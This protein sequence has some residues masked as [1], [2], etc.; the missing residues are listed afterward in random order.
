M[1]WFVPAK[2]TSMARLSLVP[3]ASRVQVTSIP[4]SSA[5]GSAQVQ[6]AHGA[7]AWA[8][9][10]SRLSKRSS[11]V[12]SALA[13]A[14]TGTA[15]WTGR[16]TLPRV[17]AARAPIEAVTVAVGVGSGV[18][19]VGSGVVGVGGFASFRGV[20]CRLARGRD[21]VERGEVDRIVL[22]LL[23]HDVGLERLQHLRLQLE[24]GQLQQL[25]GLLQLRGHR[26]LL[27]EL[28]LQGRLE[29]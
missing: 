3:D 13:E 6:G 17:N 29:H 22:F 14:V 15:T 16:S 7:S 8:V 18:V 10:A 21:L 26:K 20:C 27:T 2:P 28:E 23:E 11:R 4:A 19:G 25:D 1:S 12:S 5:T 24:H 9:A